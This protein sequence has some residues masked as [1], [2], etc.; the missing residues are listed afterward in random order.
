MQQRL[1]I[2]YTLNFDGNWHVGSG[3]RTT[4]TDRLIQRLGGRDGLPFVPGSQIK[5]VLRHTCERL[6]SAF[7]LDSVDPH[8]TSREQQQRLIE[9]FQPLTRSELI[10][11]RLFGT[12]YQGE[13]LFVDNAVPSHEEAEVPDEPTIGTDVR[14]RTAMDRLTRTVKERH[15]FS[16][17]HARGDVVLTGRIR[18]RHLDGVL[19][20]YSD[21]LPFEYSLLVAGLLTIDKLGGDKS[22]GLGSCEVNA[23]RIRW[24]GN[25]IPTE[26][27]LQSFQ[28]YDEWDQWVKVLREE[29]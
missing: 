18:A 10:I 28:E 7:N 17:E 12:R 1:D 9:A 26:Q 6:A 14:T 5:G 23:T 25:D 16:T 19:T 22:S 20:Q 15:L 2:E 29:G 3:F 24:N 11:D 27:C 8:A 4:A 21:S 13:C